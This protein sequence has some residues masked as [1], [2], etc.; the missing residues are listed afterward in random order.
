MPSARHSLDWGGNVVQI[1]QVRELTRLVKGLL[2]EDP[3]LGALAVE[4]EIS[5]FKHHSSG[6]M[7]FSLK[8]EDSVINCVMFARQSF[9]LGFT[10]QDGLRVVCFGRI[11]VYEKRGTYQLYV[12]QMIEAG[13]G[14][15]QRAFEELKAKLAQEG[16]FDPTRKRPLPFLPRC[17]GVVTSPTGA[18]IR[19]IISVITRRHPGVRILLSPALVQGEGAPESIVAALELLDA[20]GLADVVIVGRGGGSLEELWAFND[21]RVARAIYRCSVPV[22]SAVGHE[23]DFTIADFVADH[24]APTPSAAAEMVVPDSRQLKLRVQDLAT[25]LQ[26][27]LGQGLALRRRQ[28][29][30]LEKRRALRLPQ[31][32]LDQRYQRLD[33]LYRRLEVAEQRLAMT[34]THQLEKLIARLEGLS[35][36][37]ILAR[38]YAICQDET[39]GVIRKLAELPAEGVFWI[40]FSDGRTKARRLS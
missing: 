6:H 18:A 38:G 39:G 7:Y 19:D 31:D 29:E 36:L 32:L 22:V 11:G 10:P 23:T 3:R 24:R 12:A 25:R 9:Q 14:A 5:N 8:D 27:S 15:L 30:A 16:L 40:Q 20:Q 21:E 1:L 33:E 37:G 28:L 4:G 2:E 13:E 34:R 17:V 26:G 35:P